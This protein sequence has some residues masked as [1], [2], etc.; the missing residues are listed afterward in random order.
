MSSTRIVEVAKE[1]ASVVS[2]RVDGYRGDLVRCLIEVIQTQQEG[3]SEKG[4]RDKVG[5]IVE[6]LGAK[7]AARGGQ[8]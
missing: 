4:R 2:E 5:R 7:V 8:T 6:S 3:L 1:T